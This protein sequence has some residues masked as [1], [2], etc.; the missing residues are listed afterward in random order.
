MFLVKNLFPSMLVATWVTGL[1]YATAH[2]I[3]EFWQL[4]GYGTSWRSGYVLDHL[5]SILPFMLLHLFASLHAMV[6][7][8][9]SFRVHTVRA[10]NIQQGI[11][12]KPNANAVVSQ[13]RRSPSKLLTM[14]FAGAEQQRHT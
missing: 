6:G 8:T 9:C 4:V 1:L 12:S 14:A 2:Y 11:A 7:C 3:V 13:G 10:C 5:S